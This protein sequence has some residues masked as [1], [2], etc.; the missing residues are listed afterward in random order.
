MA[1]IVGYTVKYTLPK[2]RNQRRD[3]MSHGNRNRPQATLMA[4]ALRKAARFFISLL[5]VAILVFVVLFRPDLVPL[6]IFIL[7]LIACLMI[8]G[9]LIASVLWRRRSGKYIFTPRFPDALFTERWLSGRGHKRVMSQRVWGSNCMW[10][11]I[12]GDCLMV[13]HMFPFNLMF[14]PEKVGGEYEIPA[15]D[16]VSVTKKSSFFGQTIATVRFR[17]DAAVDSELDLMVRDLEGF[18]SAMNILT[19]SERSAGLTQ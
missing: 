13:G 7:F 11:A 9:N 3:I 8:P 18:V 6:T 2:D 19:E 14:L 4:Q 10:V 5:P 15:L 12:T 17:L 1:Q 16:I